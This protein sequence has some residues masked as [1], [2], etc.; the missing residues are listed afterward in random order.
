VPAYRYRAVSASGRIQRGQLAAAHENELGHFLRESGLELIE[1]RAQT[2]IALPGWLRGLRERSPLLQR[3]NLCSQL[4]DLL[5]A[6]L[7]FLTALHTVINTV[8]PGLL[9][10][11]LDSIAHAINHGSPIAAAFARHPRLFNPV[12]LAVLS[13]GE[14]SGDL[15][16]TFAQLAKQLRWQERLQIQLSRT[17]RYPLFL[18]CLALGVMT[19]MMT[20]VVPQVIAFLNSISGDLPFLTRLLIRVSEGFAA[21]GW[22]ALVSLVAGILILFTA[23]RYSPSLAL[24][25]DRLLLALPGLGPAIRKIA[26]ARFAQSLALLL[27]SGVS[28]PSSLRY[29]TAV[30][31]NRALIEAANFAERQIQAG[32][33]LSSATVDVFPPL[34][35]QMLRV[36]EQSGQLPKTLDEVTRYYDAEVQST[37]ERFIGSLEPALTIAVGALLA[38]VVLAVL[39]PVYGSLAKVGMMP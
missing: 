35:T 31:G 32:H 26:V 21:G 4:E 15:A 24:E 33:T 13:T 8:A 19:F 37:V 39:G 36:G 27:Q 18:L 11:R 38:W 34:V 12:F 30:L 28:L 23:K 16:A 14:T 7:P 10:D 6:G 3:V 22:L 17:L 25:Q 5:R 9:R 20:M 2:P 29:A 1:A